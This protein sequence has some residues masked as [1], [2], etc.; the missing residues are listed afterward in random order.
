MKHT[1]SASLGILLCC[2][3]LQANADTIV[4]QTGADVPSGIQTLLELPRSAFKERLGHPGQYGWLKPGV[5][6]SQYHKIMIAPLVILNQTAQQQ[7]QALVTDDQGKIAV[8]FQQNLVTALQKNGIAVTNQAGPDVIRL[9]VAVRNIEQD[10]DGFG[11]TDILP[12]KVVF[13]LARIVAGKESYIVRIG[14]VAQLENA[15]TGELLAGTIGLRQQDKAGKEAISAE[16]LEKWL[17]NWNQ[18]IATR[19]ALLLPSVV[20]GTTSVK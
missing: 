6:L 2:M 7:W 16:K 11:I 14:T 1:L 9:R 15:E 5:D 8:L 10:K 12:V 3:A 18:D 4:S 13:N 20:H 19:I 17:D